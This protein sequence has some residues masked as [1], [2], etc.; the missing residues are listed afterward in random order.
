MAK[1]FL[2]AATVIWLAGVIFLLVLKVPFTV[3]LLWPLVIWVVLLARRIMAR[4]DL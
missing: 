3:A 4:H 1:F 2:S